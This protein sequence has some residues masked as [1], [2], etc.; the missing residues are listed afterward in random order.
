MLALCVM[1]QIKCKTTSVK[2]KQ[3][4]FGTSD[5]NPTMNLPFLI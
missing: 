3:Y 1:L 4:I 2:K 5:L